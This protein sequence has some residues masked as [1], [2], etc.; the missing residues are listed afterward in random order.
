MRRRNHIGISLAEKLRALFSETKEKRD[1]HV[2]KTYEGTDD[3][4]FEATN[5]NL[6]TVLRLD[7][8]PESYERDRKRFGT[9]IRLID[10]A[11]DAIPEQRYKEILPLKK[12]YKRKCFD[13]SY[14]ADLKRYGT[15]PGII[16]VSNDNC[17]AKKKLPV[18]PTDFSRAAYEHVMQKWKVRDTSTWS[19]NPFSDIYRDFPKVQINVRNTSTDEKEVILWSASRE[20]TPNPPKPEEVQHH[21]ITN[22]VNVPAGVHPQ[23]MAVN[24]A[25]HYLYIANQLSGSVTVLN[26]LNQVVTIIQLEPAF[27]GFTSPVAIAINTNPGSSTYG[28]AYVAC[29][30]SNAIAV[31][32]LALQVNTVVSTG[33]RPVAIAFNPVNTC[34]YTTNLVSDTVTLIDAETF[35]ELPNSPLPAGN[36]PIGLGVNPSNGEVYIANSLSDT[37]TVYDYLHT[38]IATIAGIGQYPVSVTFN[39]A[40]NSMYAISEQSDMV[41]QLH[42]VTHTITTTLATGQRPYNS[43]FDSANN[44][45]YIQNR[46]DNTFTIIRPDNSKVDG[47]SFGPQ[48]IGGVFNSFTGSIYVSNTAT[49]S[50][51]VIG[52]ANAANVL[53]FS[54]DYAELREELKNSPAIVQHTKFV[55]T[56]P[57]RL[58]T[59]RL[60]KF[61]PTGQ[62]SSKPLSLELYASPQASLNVAEVTELAGTIIDGK[63]NWQFRLPGLHSVT[64]L[65]WFRQ[66]DVRD[67]ISPPENVSL[68][69]SNNHEK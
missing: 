64:I 48:N 57:E 40:N 32:D 39:P 17:K 25:N 38:H 41:Y 67:L 6:R 9:R 27:V 13:Q 23:G 36:D 63:M 24:P 61:T 15:Q 45:L 1:S 65:I 58:N 3:N 16:R 10:V 51:N 37:V 33:V 43:F 30:V 31:I 52:Y 34:V 26:H 69:N 2:E 56:G 12:T 19:A 14:E 7:Q 4:F 20:I 68:I 47:L 54:P 22:Q 50:I 59:F 42:P 5:A 49:N 60:T 53:V 55:V 66:L 62:Q 29:S 18:F 11:D 8:Q 21:S 46:G 44:Y 28:F 35:M